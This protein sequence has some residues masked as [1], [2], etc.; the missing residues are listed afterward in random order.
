MKTHGL[1][2]MML[3]YLLHIITQLHSKHHFIWCVC[4]QYSWKIDSH[5]KIFSI[6]S[7]LA[8]KT[9]C[10]RHRKFRTTAARVSS[11]T[12]ITAAEIAVPRLCAD[13]FCK[14]QHNLPRLLNSETPN[15]VMFA[16]LLGNY[17]QLKLERLFRKTL[18]IQQTFFYMVIA[19]ILYP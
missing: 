13:Y 17:M 14:L 5:V 16:M 19:N 2:K 8:S 18:Y 1:S 12:L 4:A 3:Q 6:C 11:L 15:T 9:I 7:P 10:S